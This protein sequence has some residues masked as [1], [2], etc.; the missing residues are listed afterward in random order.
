VNGARALITLGRI[1]ARGVAR[2]PMLRWLVIVPLVL[3][4]VIRFGIPVFAERLMERFGFDLVPYYPLVASFLL[5]FMPVLAGTVIGFLLLDER[6]DGTLTALQVTPLGLGGYLAYR[7]A[8]P[9]LASTAFTLVILPLSGLVRTDLPVLVLATLLAAPFAPIYALFLASYA[10]TKV[11]GFA[12]AKAAGVVLWPP[13]LAYFVAPEWQVLF[14]LLPTFWPMKFFWEAY[15]GAPDAWVWWI[16][17][18]VFQAAVL[19]LLLRRFD[20]AARR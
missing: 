15:A 9:M 12:L 10:R 18:M 16:A 3:L 19:A 7:L 2:D 1:D 5:L 14:G 17:G 6:D 8:A 20:R 4:P 13:V 11:E